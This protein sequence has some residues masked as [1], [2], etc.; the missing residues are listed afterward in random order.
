MTRITLI[1]SASAL[2]LAA[3]A[4]TTESVQGPDQNRTAQGAVAGALAGAALAALGPN[5]NERER[6]LAG[7][8]IGAAIGAGIGGRLDAQERALR[9]QIADNRIGIINT[10]QELIVRM[11]QD[12]LFATDSADLSGGLA[13]DLRALAA[14][15]N[16]FPQSNVVVVGH[17]DSTGT[18][19]YNQDLSERRARAVAGVL[20]GAGVAQSRLTAVGRGETDPIATN[21]TPQGRAQ[22]RRV[23]IIIRP[24]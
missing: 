12:I 22:N 13:A 19:A 11:P 15:L 16:Q 7:A 24:I 9:Q 8:A 23:D 17:A 4:P 10:G 18:E 3:C 2:V 14:N 5:D 21:A 1:A 20:L 6:A